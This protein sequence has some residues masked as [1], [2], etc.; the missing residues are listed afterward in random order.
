MN[1][2]NAGANVSDNDNQEEIVA[3]TLQTH[4]VVIAPDETDE[5]HPH[6]A[7]NPNNPGAQKKKSMRQNH[8]LAVM[9]PQTGTVYA[10]MFNNKLL[11]INP[12]PSAAFLLRN[13]GKHSR[14]LKMAESLTG[15]QNV[16]VI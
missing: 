10:L 6:W 9:N 14:V 8:K 3:K 12:K 2:Y 11:E 15:P 13:Y 16:Q 4:V 5:Q 7:D 1:I